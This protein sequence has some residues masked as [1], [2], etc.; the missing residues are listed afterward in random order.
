MKFSLKQNE[1]LYVGVAGAYLFPSIHQYEHFLCIFPSQIAVVH[2]RS[3][4]YI[5]D[6]KQS[7]YPDVF[8]A[9]DLFYPSKI[10]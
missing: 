2:R 6:H 10:L 9:S 5:K 8:L 3:L 7:K 4:H 1:I